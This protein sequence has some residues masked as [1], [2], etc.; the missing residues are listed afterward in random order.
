ML[1]CMVA[2]A[3]PLLL[4]V[5]PSRSQMLGPDDAGGVKL[6]VSFSWKTSAD[7]THGDPNGISATL[8]LKQDH[9]IVSKYGRTPEGD[10]IGNECDSKL[11]RGPD[12]KVLLSNE[13]LAMMQKCRVVAAARNENPTHHAL[14]LPMAA[15]PRKCEEIKLSTGSFRMCAAVLQLASDHLQ[16]EYEEDSDYRQHL[17]ASRTRFDVA[18]QRFGKSGHGPISG[19]T[20]KVLAA[21]SFNPRE[22]GKLA[23]ALSVGLEQCAVNEASAAANLIPP[24]ES[25]EDEAIV[26]AAE[27][28]STVCASRKGGGSIASTFDVDISGGNFTIVETASMDE[29]GNITFTNS[30]VRDGAILWTDKSSPAERTGIESSYN[31]GTLGNNVQ[32]IWGQTYRNGA[33]AFF[34]T[35]HF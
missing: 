27:H 15:G 8:I 21:F 11:A 32:G 3:G 31:A 2:I 20:V 30:N 29:H 14:L 6:Q 7:A 4:N 33:R 19:C 26:A 5:A 1:R 12:G 10:N 18:L 17:F 25:K 13:N 35:C 24:P 16:M 28:K 34:T 23:P 22:P 9:V